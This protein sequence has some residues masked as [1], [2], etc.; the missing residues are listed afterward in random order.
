MTMFQ[1]MYKKK[2]DPVEHFINYTQKVKIFPCSTVTF[3]SC[4]I[5]DKETNNF[6]VNGS[7]FKPTDGPVTYASNM[8]T[9]VMFPKAAGKLQKQIKEEMIR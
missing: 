4:E 9:E 6:L 8:S 3:F 7:I 1:D 2:I 5:K